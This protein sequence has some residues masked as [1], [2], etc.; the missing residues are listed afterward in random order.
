MTAQE[1]AIS[2]N[3]I[4]KHVDKEEYCRIFGKTEETIADIT[5]EYPSLAQN[6]Y[7]RGDH[8]QGCQ[9]HLLEVV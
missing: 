5:S 9:N 6:E 7:K 4:R 3:N 1:E 8:D 2:T